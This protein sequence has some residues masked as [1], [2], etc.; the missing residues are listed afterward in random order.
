MEPLEAYARFRLGKLSSDS[1]VALANAWLEGGVYT[2]S[3]AELC[4][5]KSPTI[6]EVGPLFESAMQELGV[7][8][9]TRAEA[10]LVLARNTLLCIAN[11]TT[12]AVEGA[13]FLYWSV[14]QELYKDIPDREYL[15]DNLDLEYVFC[16]LREIWDCRDGS[17]LLYHTELPRAEAEVKF[18]Q[19][20]IEAAQEWIEKEHTTIGCRVRL[21]S[22]PSP[23]P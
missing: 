1:I 15:G 19:H 5:V 18:K 11:G 12:D 22:S 16:W 21:T 13:E 6:T 17:M 23:E 3:L 10:G 20:L 8:D 2:K 7:K 4:T 14:H 9:I